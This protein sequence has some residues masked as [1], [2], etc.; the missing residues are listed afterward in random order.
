MK[1]FKLDLMTVLFVVVAIGVVVTMSTQASTQTSAQA[2]DYSAAGSVAIQ[3]SAQPVST[4]LPAN[5][6]WTVILDAYI[7]ARLHAVSINPEQVLTSADTA[8]QLRFADSL[9]SLPVRK[10]YSRN[11]VRFHWDVRAHPYIT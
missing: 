1:L 11:F 5:R 7:R 3:A 8:R 2:R 4:A 6:L 9:P 10:P